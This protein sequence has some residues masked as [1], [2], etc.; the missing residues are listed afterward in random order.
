MSTPSGLSTDASAS[1]SQTHYRSCHLC[2]AICGVAIQVQ[3]HHI[4]SIR[5]DKDD[6]FSRGYICP[7]AAAL[8]DIH[9]DPDRLR[10]PMRRTASGDFV[11][12]SWDQALTEVAER[13]SQ[14][15]TQHGPNSVA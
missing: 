6:P 13:L 8:A 2:E 9:D 11:R 15:K 1:G 10:H 12:V 5:G 14:I 7:K 4:V 3:D